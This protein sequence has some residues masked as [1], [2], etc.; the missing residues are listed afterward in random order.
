MFNNSIKTTLKVAGL[1]YK[2]EKRFF[3]MAVFTTTL[4][5]IIP[6]I[7]A[8]IYKLIID[9]LIN[10]ISKSS[11]I[12]FNY[13]YLLIALRIVSYITS[14]IFYQ[15]QNYFITLIAAKLP[16]TIN[17]LLLSKISSLD[18][19]YFER[20]DFKNLLEK[21]REAHNFRPQNLLT[22]FLY[23]LQNVTTLI[24]ALFAIAQ[25]NIFLTLVV[26]LFTIPEYISRLNISKVSYT[27]WSWNSPLK[28]RF[29]YIA[30]IL[31]DAKFIKELKVFG[32]GKR[33]LQDMK[34]I[35]NKFYEDN[36]SISK[37]SFKYSSSTGILGSLIFVS[38]EVYVFLQALASKITVGDVSFYSQ[39]VSNFQRGLSGFFYTV[40]NVYDDSLYVKSIFDVLDI[41]NLIKEPLSPVKKELQIPKI[42]FK[43][44]TFRYPSSKKLVLKNFSLIIEP[45][46]KIAIVGENGAGKST[47][48]KLLSRLYDVDSGEILIDGTNV[49][50]FLTQDLC[51]YFGVIYQDFCQYDYSVEENIYFG[52]ITKKLDDK[53]IFVASKKSSADT[54]INKLPHGYKQVLGTSFEGSV[55]LSQGQW[56]KIAL[57]RAFYRNASVLVLDE[58]TASI[59]ARAEAEIFEKVNSLSEGKTVI[60]IS[61]RFSTVRMADVICVISNGEI[62]EKGSHKQL[63]QQNGEYA[64]LFQLQAKGYS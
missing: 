63:M 58:P 13:L 4:L 19:E 47:I 46:Q 2:T 26:L 16:I 42:E 32:L 23:V 7:D 29:Y 30:D 22:N 35:Q 50:E 11:A 15:A 28:K 52:D 64:A 60:V 41:E 59:D 36:L 48:I 55:E 12:D 43:N 6:F 61:H 56:Q 31:Q 20:P 14:N 34:D 10:Y 51:K 38:F 27:I 40:N 39:I 18:I 54:F 62:V 25:F 3:V 9:V 49:K 8:Y 53:N 24:I 57:A 17:E 21:V 37:K 33:L 45:G 1:V 44:V 5:S